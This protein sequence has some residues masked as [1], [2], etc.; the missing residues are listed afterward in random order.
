MVQFR[1][2]EDANGKFVSARRPDGRTAI[3]YIPTPLLGSPTFKNSLEAL[4]AAISLTV[5][6]L[7][8]AAETLNET[9]LMQQA[10]A[11]F[12]STAARAFQQ[13]V[14]EG[15]KRW[16]DLDAIKTD[17]LNQRKIDPVVA[18][19]IRTYLRSMKT[20]D[21]A[22]AAL[23]DPDIAASAIAGWQLTGLPESLRSQVE[24]QLMLANLAERFAVRHRIEASA[25]DPLAYGVNKDGALSD[26]KTALASH[27]ASRGEVELLRQT[28]VSTVNFAAVA[29]GISDA[30]AHEMLTGAPQ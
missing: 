9:G 27:E 2:S 17:W 30:S 15:R 23:A 24:S 25:S 29:S 4:H 14:S 12:S 3:F 5:M 1:N 11:K 6:S 16:I 20:G 19:E 28:L 18:A 10:A 13:L 7:T 26:A 21:A 22:R 8:K